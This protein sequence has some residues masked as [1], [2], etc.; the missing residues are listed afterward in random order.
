MYIYIFN[1]YLVPGHSPRPNQ[2]EDHA[3]MEVGGGDT[4]T[5]ESFASAN[6]AKAEELLGKVIEV[7]GMTD[8]PILHKAFNQSRKSNHSRE[9]NVT[10]AIEW[11]LQMSDST[12]LNT[13][14]IKI[15]QFRTI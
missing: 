6:P 5:F 1:L 8:R 11:I 13:G 7:T 9:F 4:N 2:T 14:K 15:E 3:A 12:N 10:H